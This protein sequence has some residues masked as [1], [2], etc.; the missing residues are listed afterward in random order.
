MIALSGEEH[1]KTFFEHKGLA[2]AEGYS[3]LLAGSPS[4]KPDNNAF[5]EAHNGNSGF[6]A[7]FQRRLV[8][9]LKANR[10]EKGL[11]QLLEDVRASLEAVS[12]YPIPITNPFN[13]MYQLIFKIT[14][15]TVACDDIANDPE[16]LARCLRYFE[17]IEESATPLSIMFPRM[18][19]WSKA[20]RT[21]AGFQLY[22]I[23][24]HI[25]ET[26]SV[27]RSERHDALQ[28]LI[29]QGDSVVDII[30]VSPLYPPSMPFTDTYSL[31]LAHSS[32]DSSILES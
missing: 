26:R 25:I 32:L 28:Y 10:L 14:M 18:P 7:Y 24:K 19:L 29:D 4:V 8:T 9:M 5:A 11:P 6:T 21:H 17:T 20:K 2:C 12:A 23:F 13:S 1:R 22:T 16:L 3:T 31:S 27:N 30:S 15:R